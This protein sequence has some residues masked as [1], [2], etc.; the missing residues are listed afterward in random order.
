VFGDHRY[1]PVSGPLDVVDVAL[2]GLSAETAKLDVLDT[3]PSDKQG[4][5]REQGVFDRIYVD[6]LG[7]VI[8]IVETLAKETTRAG[9]CRKLRPGR[10]GMIHNSAMAVCR[11][12][13]TR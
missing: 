10:S 5:L 4:V 9:W 8:S 1:C 2:G 3:I 13:V 6:A 11:G 7:N 12:R